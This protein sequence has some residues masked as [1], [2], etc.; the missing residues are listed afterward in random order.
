MAESFQG[1]P[2]AIAPEGLDK[3]KDDHDRRLTPLFRRWPALDKLELAEL[4]RLWDERLRLARHSGARR[5]ALTTAEERS[6]A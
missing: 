4:H 1:D 5:R 3:A 2:W 6:S